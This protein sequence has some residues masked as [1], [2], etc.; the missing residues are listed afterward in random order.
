MDILFNLAVYALKFYG[1]FVLLRFFM[2]YFRVDFYN[3][4]SQSIVKLTNPPLIPLRKIIPGFRNM[5]IAS[6]VLALIISSIVL[7]LAFNL[8]QAISLS[9]LFIF[10]ILF[11]GQLIYSILNLFFFLL[12]IRIIMSFVMMGQGFHQ[13]PIA[14]MIFQITEPIMRPFQKL[15][16]PVGVLDFSPILLFAAIWVSQMV[17]NKVAQSIAPGLFFI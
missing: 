16:P 13:N 2:Q 9:N 5:D 8:W 15:I 14:E 6:L 17:L 3:P 10:L 11:I 4:V 1:F 12:I 7:S